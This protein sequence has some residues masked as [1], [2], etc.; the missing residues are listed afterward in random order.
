MLKK[1]IAVVI[2]LLISTTVA[3]KTLYNPTQL[4]QFQNTNKCSG[5]D[6]SNAAIYGNHSGAYLSNANLT[7][8]VT[9][10]CD[11]SQSNFSGANLSGSKIN[12]NLSYANFHNAI[13]TN[14]FFYNDNL[15][16]A[17]FTGAFMKDMNLSGADL[18]GAKITPTQLADVKTVCN[19]IL[20]DGSRGKCP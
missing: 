1:N 11:L 14:A 2:S 13:L 9:D 3:A 10:P 7:G 4:T 8:L 5:C 17:D 15:E 20:P 12:A 18:Y 6:L 16:F 19:A